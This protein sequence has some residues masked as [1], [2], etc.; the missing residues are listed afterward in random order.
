MEAE[1]RKMRRTLSNRK[2]GRET[3]NKEKR[4]YKKK[5][6]RIIYVPLAYGPPHVD[7]NQDMSS[8]TIYSQAAPYHKPDNRQ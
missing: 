7:K 6:K 8:H 3:E 5:H 1:I 4:P 2:M